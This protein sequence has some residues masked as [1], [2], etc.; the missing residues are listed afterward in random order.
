M[1]RIDALLKHMEIINGE[2]YYFDTVDYMNTMH[3]LWRNHKNAVTTA[4][5]EMKQLFVKGVLV[6]AIKIS[7]SNDI[8]YQ[9]E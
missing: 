2:I 4:A 1:K 3:E 9:S 8:K 6:I 7:R 5:E